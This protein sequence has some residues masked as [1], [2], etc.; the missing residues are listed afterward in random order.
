MSLKLIRPTMSQ[1]KLDLSLLKS[2][3]PS[4]KLFLISSLFEPGFRALMFWRAQNYFL[5]IGCYKFAQLA[6][7]LNLLLH[8][9]EICVGARIGAPALIRHPCGI[10]IGSG[11]RIGK[12]CTIL[13][14]VTI[15]LSNVMT[16][17]ANIYPTLKNNIVLGANCSVLGSI[18]IADNT[19]VGSHSLVLTDTKPNSTYVGIPAKP[20][21]KS[22]SKSE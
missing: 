22:R 20:I 1:V 4:L 9:A 8:G 16:S 11:V 3:K 12:N 14:G 7:N 15:G 2:E 10:V 13:Q 18:S 5:D 17:G 6:S 21:K 19:L